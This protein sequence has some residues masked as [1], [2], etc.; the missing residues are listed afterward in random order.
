MEEW[1]QRPNPTERT[2]VVE[3]GG[4]YGFASL[5]LATKRPELSFEVRC[6]SQEFLRHGK[7]SVDVTQFEASIT[8]THLPLF[9]AMHPDDSRTVWVFVLRNLLWN[10]ADVD[11]IKLLQTLLPALRA[12]R[13]VRILVTDGISP[14]PKEFPPHVEIAY[15]RRDI[16]TMTMHNAKQRSQAEWLALFSRVSPALQVSIYLILKKGMI[17]I[18]I[19]DQIWWQQFARVQRLVGDWSV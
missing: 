10:W 17:E 3:I 15:R 16:T 8:F 19:G 4:R 11:A 7:V 6:D 12:S 13:S 2:K 1:F 5:L 14:E 18:C 9:N